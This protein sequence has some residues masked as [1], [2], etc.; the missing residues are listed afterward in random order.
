MGL[1][2]SFFEM[3]ICEETSTSGKGVTNER[4]SVKSLQ[5]L[6]T[7][8]HRAGMITARKRENQRES[9]G[10]VVRKQW[11]GWRQSCICLQGCG[12]SSVFIRCLMGS[13]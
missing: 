3:G 9:Q 12:G 5:K 7:G 11:A 13:S 10:E 6:T 8:G 1:E 4:L 2:S